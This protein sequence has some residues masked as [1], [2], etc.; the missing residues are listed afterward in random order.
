MEYSPLGTFGFAA[1]EAVV[2]GRTHR[3]QRR[4]ENQDNFIICDLSSGDEGLVLR[5]DVPDVPMAA[6]EARLSVGP[7]G[8][9]MLVADGMGGAAAGRLASSLACTFILAELQNGWQ[10]DREITPRQFVFRLAEAVAQANTRIHAHS[11]RNAETSGMGTTATAAGIFDGF[12]YIAQVG[13]SRAYV[14]RNGEATQ[15]TRDQSLVQHMIDAG[16][17][18]PQNPQIKVR[19]NIIMQALGVRPAVDV[20]VTYHELRRDDFLLLCSDGLHGLLRDDEIAAVVRRLVS[21]A[22]VCD[23]LIIMANERGGPD[24]VTAVAGLFGGGLN[25]ATTGEAVRRLSYSGFGDARSV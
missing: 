19:G 4:S 11:M 8:A 1:V 14:I 25:G 12:L 3:G 13:D 16:A 15:V 23:E 9:L 17:I 6:G 10:A 18:D 2:A 7:R 5:P 20:D 24:N 22:A 21:P